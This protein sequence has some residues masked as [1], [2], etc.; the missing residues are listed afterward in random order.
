MP[1]SIHR[2]GRLFL[3]STENMSYAFE[4]R[5]DGS[6]VNLHWGG[7]IQRAEDLP[8][9]DKISFFS[10]SHY[11]QRVRQKRLEYSAYRAGDHSVPCLKLLSP[12]TAVEL[13]Y[14]SSRLEN[15]DHLIVTMRDRKSGIRTDLHYLLHPE[16]DLL[17]R[18]AE[19]INEGN[20]ELCF[21]SLLSAIWVL[22][23]GNAPRLT[24]LH[25]IKTKQGKIWD[26]IGKHTV[27]RVDPNNPMLRSC[28]IQCHGLPL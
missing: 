21:E 10:R 25:G 27:C 26:A 9:V 23:R 12:D 22:P 3:G 18:Y 13:L 20:D 19:I 16:F 15:P 14:E 4:I 1:F 8:P 24:T 5:E 2:N 28:G 6:A 17:S 11:F 7:R